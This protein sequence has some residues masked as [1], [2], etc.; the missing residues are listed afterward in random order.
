[1]CGGNDTGYDDTMDAMIKKEEEISPEKKKPDYKD[2][3]AEIQVH[4][5]IKIETGE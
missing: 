4:G 1:M 2:L 5:A 3:K